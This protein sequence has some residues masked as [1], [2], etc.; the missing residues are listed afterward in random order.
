MPLGQEARSLGDVDVE[1]MERVK[2]TAH[3]SL[4]KQIDLAA[5]SGGGD[6]LKAEEMH[7]NVE[8]IVNELV[9]VESVGS[10][11]E[12]ARLRQEV[13][14]EALGYGPLEDLLR[15]PEV[16]EIMVNGKDH[17]YVERSGKI[18]LSNKTFT[19]DRQL[20]L[21][22]ER[23]VA[24]IGRRIDEATP[25]VDGRLPDG[26]RINAI[27]EPLAIDGPSLTVRRFGTERLT[28]NNLVAKNAIAPPVVDFLR[29]CVESRLNVVISGGTGSGKTTLLNIL[30]GFIP[31]T[32]RIVTIEDAAELML[33]QE[34]VVRLEARPPNLEGR[35]E[36]RI[37]DLVRNALRMR[38]DRIIVG[39]CRGGEALDM[40]QAMN[41]GHD[42][43]L[44]TLHANTP[45][46]CLSR[47]ETL[48]MMAGF[49]IPVRAIR[50]QISGA[51]DIIV[52]V[53]RLRDGS[54]KVTSVTE[55]VGMEGDMITMHD[56]FTFVP[57][58]E[59]EKGR[60]TG[61]FRWSGIMPRF[62]RRIA[63][64]G[65]LARLETALGVKLPKN[66]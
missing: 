46:D 29:A 36:I 19:S 7:K 5:A 65:E 66:F 20:R 22:I 59:D 34:H 50:E 13:I 52:Q 11:E 30:S 26:S 9:T 18:K 40:L 53:A 25:M 6:P 45:R 56:L 17:I 41:T 28:I 57:D 63:Y 39:E 64:Y 43:S 27:I 62:V 51:I 44:T 54:R 35:G 61:D 23:M 42:G 47:M 4:S 10:A 24:P 31:E 2:A 12:V 55:V 33:N 21:V 3:D 38:P 37:R 49:D 8:R 32:D 60:L 1:K 48:V 58:G 15:D 14:D 16:T